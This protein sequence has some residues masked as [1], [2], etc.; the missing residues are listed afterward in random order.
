MGFNVGNN[1]CDC[2]NINVVREEKGKS[3]LICIQNSNYNNAVNPTAITEKKWKK[4]QI[5]E[6]KINV[7]KTTPLHL[8][9]VKDVK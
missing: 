2:S 4:E 8:I 5:W 1:T 6:K 7:I 3:P 9:N